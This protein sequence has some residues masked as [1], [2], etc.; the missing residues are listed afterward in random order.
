MNRP[1]S[2]VM[3]EY[4]L[5]GVGG[6]GDAGVRAALSGGGAVAGAVILIGKGVAGNRGAVRKFLDAGSHLSDI[7]VAVIPALA[8]FAAGMDAASSGIKRVAMA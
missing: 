6:V 3:L 8:A 5:R 2:V 4:W 7:V 1:P